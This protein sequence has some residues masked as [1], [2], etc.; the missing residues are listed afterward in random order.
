MAARRKTA[1][2]K[3]APKKGA[4]KKQKA[5][6]P[7]KKAAPKEPKEVKPGPPVE[8]VMSVVTGLM[9]L[10]TV[11]LVDYARGVKYGTGSIFGD[12]YEAPE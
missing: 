7:K 10:A 6:K 8:V 9:I 2:K 5:A 11:L 12:K 4:A 1:K 3:A